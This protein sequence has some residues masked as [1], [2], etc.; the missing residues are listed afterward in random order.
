MSGN[1]ASFKRAILKFLKKKKNRNESKHSGIIKTI[2]I[3][4]NAVYQIVDIMHVYVLSH[5]G[6]STL[7]DSMDDDPLR[8]LSPA[9]S[10]ARY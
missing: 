10:Q 3:F 4:K 7:C 1:F 8:L 2:L 5:F 9:S 6:T